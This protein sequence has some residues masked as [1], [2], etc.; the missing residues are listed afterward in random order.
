[1]PAPSPAAATLACTHP[2]ELTVDLA[3]AADSAP[4]LARLAA[5]RLAHRKVPQWEHDLALPVTRARAEALLRL[6]KRLPRLERL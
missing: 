6:L 4:R 1:M 3:A 2:Q 5:L